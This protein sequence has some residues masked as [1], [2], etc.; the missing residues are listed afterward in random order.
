MVKEEDVITY[1]SEDLGKEVSED[2]LMREIEQDFEED[3]L[4][5]KDLLEDELGDVGYTPQQE[6]DMNPVAFLERNLNRQDKIS[7]ANLT[8]E[9]LGRPTLPVRFWR[10]YASIFDGTTL[11]NMPLVNIHLLKKAKINEATSLSKEAKALELAITN[12]RVRERKSSKAVS[13]FLDS[14]KKRREVA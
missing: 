7:V 12:K 1:S 10:Q 9:E 4:E 5:D 2:E 13:D 6:K 3:D 8:T 11:Y 14:V